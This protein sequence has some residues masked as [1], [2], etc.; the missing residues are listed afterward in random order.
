MFNIV[1]QIIDGIP[2]TVVSPHR[3]DNQNKVIVLTRKEL[4]ERA[5][6]SIMRYIP[7]C[8]YYVFY[9]PVN[10]QAMQAF[11]K[12]GN[13]IVAGTHCMTVIELL[14]R[15]FKVYAFKIS[16]EGEMV[17]LRLVE[18]VISKVV[19]SKLDATKSF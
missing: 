19:W 17:E 11:A 5:V 1:T 7:A 12:I 4:A 13:T 2:F 10:E 9:R 3:C 16:D 18:K 14:N 6:A 15:G 8:M